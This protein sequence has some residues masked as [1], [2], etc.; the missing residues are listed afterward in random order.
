MIVAL[1]AAN[2]TVAEICAATGRSRVFVHDRLAEAGVQA[3]TRPDALGV[4][5]SRLAEV[6]RA[7]RSASV[8]GEFFHIG[9]R[10]VLSRLREYGAEIQPAAGQPRSAGPDTPPVVIVFPQKAWERKDTEIV[11][12][13]INRKESAA[14][15]AADMGITLKNVNDTVRFHLHRDRTASEIIRRGEKGEPPNV[16]AARLGIRPELVSTL[17]SGVRRQ[18]SAER[19]R[20]C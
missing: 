15:I 6:Y 16:I 14:H 19:S 9:R 11:A 8:T 13:F 4:D 5:P 7:V 17:L 1:H 18:R 12:R 20:R 3:R 10:S 2:L